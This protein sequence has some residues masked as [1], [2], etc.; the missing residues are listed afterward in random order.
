MENYDTVEKYILTINCLDGKIYYSRPVFTKISNL[1]RNQ[2]AEFGSCPKEVDIPYKTNEVK[3]I[4]LLH[5]SCSEIDSMELLYKNFDDLNRYVE[6]IAYLDLE[7][8]PHIDFVWETMPY[9]VENKTYVKLQNPDPKYKALCSGTCGMYFLLNTL[10]KNYGLC[11]NCA[12]E[13]KKCKSDDCTRVFKAK[14]L[15]ASDGYCKWCDGSSMTQKA[16]QENYGHEVYTSK[17]AIQLIIKYAESQ[18]P[19]M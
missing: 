8:P 19:K 10:N 13:K 15:L 2:T 1:Y 9:D 14:T 4:L 11:G 7:M 17:E 3:T 16:M 18:R 6:L 5:D 12:N